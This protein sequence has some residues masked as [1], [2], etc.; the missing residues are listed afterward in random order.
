MGE[1]EGRGSGYV[2][3]VALLGLGFHWLTSFL[4]VTVGRQDRRLA[5]DTLS[6]ERPHRHTCIEWL[7]G[8]EK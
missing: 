3:S 5:I 8:H 7:G 1:R 4:S 2:E 6:R